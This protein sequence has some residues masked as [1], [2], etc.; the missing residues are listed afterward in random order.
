MV[1]YAAPINGA[2]GGDETLAERRAEWIAPFL[3][4]VGDTL[5]KFATLWVVGTG[6]A[7]CEAGE[8]IDVR[9]D[10]VM[11]FGLHVRP[12]FG[13]CCDKCPV[14]VD[15]LPPVRHAQLRC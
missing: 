15:G 2:G 14:G 5:G 12:E 3:A 4:R 8:V 10:E 13:E 6:V 11:D 1:G 9:L 7:G